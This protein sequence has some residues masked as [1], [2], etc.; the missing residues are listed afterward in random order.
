MRR[1]RAAVLRV[2][3]CESRARNVHRAERRRRRRRRER[4]RFLLYPMRACLFFAAA[5]ERSVYLY[6]P[7]VSKLRRRRR[8]VPDV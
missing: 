6:E 8:R 4:V 2:C 7:R 5:T 1:R 3:V